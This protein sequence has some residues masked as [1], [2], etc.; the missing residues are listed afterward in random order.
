MTTQHS[1]S[2]A[3]SSREL[4]TRT[5]RIAS[6]VAA[7][8]AGDV[9]A[10][11]RFPTETFAALREARVLSAVVPE[12]CGG[13]GASM[14]ALVEMCSV[15][16]QSCGSSA[17]VLA[18]HH[19]QVACIA[20]H[21]KGTPYFDAYM[22]EIAER[23]ILMASV[24]SEVGVGGDTRSS[25]CALER[26]DDR[27]TL[28][29]DATTVSYGEAAED[30][31]ITCRRDT[32]APRS[33]QLLVLIRPGNYRLE[34][35]GSW[36]TL[37]MRGTC[38]PSFKVYCEGPLE[39]VLPVPFADISA[40]TMVPYSHVLWA[41]LW[42][43]IASDAVNRAAAFVRATAR[44]NPGTTPPTAVR[45]AEVSVKLQRLRNN[46]LATA[47]E[48]DALG[49]DREALGT[50]AWALRFNN[51]KV[52]ASEAAPTIVHDALQITGIMGY[53][54]DSPYSVGRHYRDLL[55]GA[56]MVGN[57]RILAKSASMLLVAK[58]EQG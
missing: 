21:G 7:R 37:G 33:D 36:D 18:M 24:T 41:A 32:S 39:Q 22:R 30:L 40:E 52:G 26:K 5:R 51:L 13:S 42:H 31:L 11:A 28:N 6:E 4:I 46:I 25:I 43:G 50:M 3:P 56:L 38:S 29:K 14:Q 44:K 45:L 10:R 17:M 16:G 20:R 49:D 47:M 1:A 12:E 54:N 23:Q 58:G 55:S 35:R 48:F 27:F 8:H 2:V 19:I 9:D 15:L 34:G 53:K 57:E